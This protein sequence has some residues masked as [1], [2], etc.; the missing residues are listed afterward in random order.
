MDTSGQEG[1]VALAERVP[2]LA[3]RVSGK[4][5]AG[6]PGASGSLRIL[7]EL[8]LRA[9]DEHAAHLTPS[10]QEL[11]DG[12]GATPA[13]LT[14]VVVGSG[15]GSF[16]G[17]RVAASTAKGLAWSRGLP[18]WAF[19]SL[20]AA[21]VSVDEEPIRPRLVLFDARADRV[22][23]A[24][25]R[26]AHGNLETLLEP[27]AT[28]VGQVATALIPPGALMMGDGAWRHRALLESADGQILPPPAGWPRARGL[29][30]ILGLRPEP[31]PV[32]DLA[33]WEPDYLRSSGAER[34]L[35]AGRGK[36]IS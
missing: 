34:M 24:A 4:S 9:Q 3:E 11:L 7:G 30:R 28:T 36:G 5:S 19:S 25:Y 21:A 10:I 32:G 33:L 29:L 31:A 27:R 6:I 18:L 22:Y 35:Q 13:D 15:P 14:G 20:A 2:A 8:E 1:S 23:A 26:V 12:V 17:V 16:T